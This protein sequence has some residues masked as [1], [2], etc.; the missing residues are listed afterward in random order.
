MTDFTVNASGTLVML[1]GLRR[2]SPEAVFVFTSTNKVCGDT[3]NSLP[4]L[5]KKLRWE[6]DPSHRY[7]RH[8]IDETMSIDASKHRLSARVR[9]R[10]TS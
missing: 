1:E 5:E 6:V 3:P 2:H 4:F 7:A 9:S 8:G 10:P